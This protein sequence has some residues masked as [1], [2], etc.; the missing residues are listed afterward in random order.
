[1]IHPHAVQNLL[2][3]CGHDPRD[4]THTEAF[5]SFAVAMGRAPSDL[6]ELVQLLRAAAVQAIAD[7]DAG[8][9]E[10]ADS[11]MREELCAVRDSGSLPDERAWVSL[12]A[13]IRGAA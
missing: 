9:V 7:I 5:D 8:E 2:D 12:D 6:G 4:W 13:E 1:M 11:D 10:D 3:S